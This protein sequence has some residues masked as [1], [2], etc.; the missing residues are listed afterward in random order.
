MGC[1]IH[2]YV[3]YKKTIDGVTN[4]Y[5]GDYLIV[6]PYYG[7]DEYESKYDIVSLYD[8]RNYDL[9]AILADV[10]NGCKNKYIS[11]PKG[12]PNDITNVTAKE[13][14]RWRYDGHSYSYLTL[15]ELLEFEPEPIK[16]KGYL[17]KED[18]DKLDAGIIPTCWCTWT[19]RKDC[20]YREWIDNTNDLEPLIK[21]LKQRA[22]ELCVIYNWQW[23]HEPNKA[24][25]QS[26]NIRI[27]FWF[28]N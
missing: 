21:L 25:T 23:E 3:E 13:A 28:D 19:N 2:L 14:F 9:F 24:L 1:D 18:A 27:V 8:D 17:D 26:E 11:L 6:N 20:I 7:T 22:H 10:R 16:R 4:W 15:K 5:S 12:L